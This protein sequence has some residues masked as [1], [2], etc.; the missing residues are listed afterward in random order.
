[1]MVTV[2]LFEIFFELNKPLTEIRGRGGRVY[3]CPRIAIAP[4]TGWLPRLCCR[5]RGSAYVTV[6]AWNQNQEPDR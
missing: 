4:H 3:V 6:C 5:V 2:A 1:M